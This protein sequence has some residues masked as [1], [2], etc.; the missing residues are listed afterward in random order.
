MSTTKTGVS[1]ALIVATITCVLGMAMLSPLPA[2]AAPWL[3]STRLPTRTPRPL[4]T[5]PPTPVP[6]PMPV[7]VPAPTRSFTSPPQP[8]RGGYIELHV[9]IAPAGLWTIVQ[10]QGSLGEWY[11]VEGWQGTLDEGNK[12]TWWVAGADCGKG[13]FRWVISEGP[14][15][16]V[17]ATS[18][19]FYL[20]GWDN[21]T[22]RV[23][24]QL[25]P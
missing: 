4:P 23:E 14:Q 20:P 18:A 19:P 25:T 5:R 17:L 10:W 1:C 8:P 3:V 13:P 9:P 15:G 21:S 24:A 11:D 22:V 7:P 2:Q 16:P 12:K 6:T